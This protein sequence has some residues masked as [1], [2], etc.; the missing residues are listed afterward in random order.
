MS[1][2]T[3]F[4]LYT[5]FLILLIIIGISESIY[6]AQKDL[7]LTQLQEN[8]DK[9]FKDLSYACNEALAVNDQ[10]QVS[11]TIK[12]II[13]THNPAIV[14]AGYISA[15][16]T[17][18]FAARDPDQET[19]LKAK[20]KKATR[21]GTADVLSPI[22]EKIY[23]YTQPFYIKSVYRGTLRAG[24]SY[25]YIEYQVK[26]GLHTIVKKIVIVAVIS[27]LIGVIFANILAAYFNKP[28]LALAKAADEIGAGNMD[29]KV[30]VDRRDELGRLAKTFNQ[31]A[32]K[33]KELDE[34]KDGFVSSV[35]HELRSP[36]AAIDGYCD[37]LLD[38]LSK[39]LTPD[40]QEK[41]LKIIKDAT[42]RLT[43]FINN[44]LDI[45][46]IKAGRFEVRRASVN[47]GEI[48]KE[49]VAL[50]ESL[51]AQNNK[52]LYYE[53]PNVIPNIDADP[54]KIKQVITNLVGNAM[55]FTPA[56]GE[57]KVSAFFNPAAMTENLGGK[58]PAEFIEVWVADTGVGIPPEAVNRVFDKFYQVKE[59]DMKK[60][61]GTGLGLAIVAE[62]VKLHGGTIWAE[63]MLG[64]G[65]TFKFTLPVLKQVSIK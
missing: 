18:L 3:K 30:S 47:L 13:K 14:Y 29:V 36:L 21:A 56:G 62:I 16:D 5:S 34:L 48:V 59:S 65:S 53:I 28:I 45:A 12:T 23:E 61:K 4:T 1:L 22:G 42:I 27:L 50:F 24:F 58:M 49:I 11:N 32:R 9:I 20:I 63:S 39:G 55:K 40:K 19:K 43:N 60:P 44:I 2:R 51:A 6:L 46:K 33:L 35:S 26:E 8:R 52:K 54:E 25:S 31:M 37:L 10:I 7:L 64:K 57:I 38:G 41:S 15:T 17:V